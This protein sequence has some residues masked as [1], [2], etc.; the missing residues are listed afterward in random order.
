MDV[1]WYGGVVISLQD[2]FV[3]FLGLVEKNSKRE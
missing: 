2:F 1:S 3:Y